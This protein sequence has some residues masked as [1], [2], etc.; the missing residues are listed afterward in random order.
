MKQDLFNHV[1]STVEHEERRMALKRETKSQHKSI[2]NRYHTVRCNSLGISHTNFIFDKEALLDSLSD[3]E[4]AEEIAKVLGQS[5]DLE[6]NHFLNIK[7]KLEEG[8]S[9]SKHSKSSNGG[10]MDVDNTEDKGEELEMLLVL[11]NLYK[12]DCNT[13][14]VV[15]HLHFYLGDNR[16][17]RNGWNPESF[18]RHVRRCERSR[19][20]NQIIWGEWSLVS[21]IEGSEGFTSVGSRAHVQSLGKDSNMSLEERLA[22]QKKEDNKRM[23]L[24]AKS[25]RRE[26]RRLKQLQKRGKI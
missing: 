16:A 7:E 19:D 12:E 22:K 13:D 26:A 25:D 21:F 4:N 14:S 23:E 9:S 15:S 17:W 5:I 11:Y 18:K 10:M 8:H 3:N 1:G 6:Q 20:N 2:H 24:Q